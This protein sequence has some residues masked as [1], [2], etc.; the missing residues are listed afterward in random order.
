MA[1]FAF[2]LARQQTG[3]LKA[4]YKAGAGSRDGLMKEALFLDAFSRAKE[5]I[6]AMDV[7][8]VEEVDPTR[9][10][11]L[12]IYTAVVLGTPYNDFDTH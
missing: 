3:N 2:R 8:F 1:A 6:R 11:L 12:E 9:Q 7:R 5:R 10:A 4:A